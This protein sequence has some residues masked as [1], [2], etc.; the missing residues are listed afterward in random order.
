MTE[1][2]SQDLV[3]GDP[4][5]A[6]GRPPIGLRTKLALLVVAAAIPLL[7]LTVLLS[8]RSYQAERAQIEQHTV[9]T[10]HA[11]A[12]AVDREMAA[13]QSALV[14]LSLSNELRNGDLRGFYSQA[15]ELLRQVRAVNLVVWDARGLQ[16]LN[17]SVPFGQKVP[18]HAS[19]PPIAPGAGTGRPVISDLHAGHVGDRPALSVD[20]Q[21]QTALGPV[22]LSFGVQP[23]LLNDI[24]FQQPLPDNWIISLLDSSGAIVARTKGIETFLGKKAAPGLLNALNQAEEGTA[25]VRTLDG[26]EV[27]SA[28]SRSAISGWTAVIGIPIE[29]LVAPL[30]RSLYAIVAVAAALLLAGIALAALIARRI[31]QPIQALVEPALAL[32]RGEPL[33]IPPL[34]LREARQLGNAI[35]TAAR[36]LKAR[37]GQRDRAEAQLRESELRFRTMADSAPVM[38]WMSGPDKSGVYF[39]KV[40][41][42][43]TGRTLEEELGH[44]WTGNV[45]PDDLPEFRACSAAFE[46]R[47][48]FQTRF[49][50]LRHDGAWRWV[51]DT[52]IPRFETDGSFAGFIGSCLDIT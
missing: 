7:A 26:I 35:E 5:G 47:R 39:N 2:A 21:A 43:F 34:R 6:L 49:R 4:V 3:S 40:W 28:F 24:L 44:R 23:E 48:P 45:H 20:L 30:R 11:L 9:E 17:T 13:L 14:V 42:D 8:I 36:L 33:P 31:E 12:L 19:A 1:P 51:L 50:M 46:M 37:E 25:E 16:L 32:G 52:G 41:L 15:E 27:L 29:H 18:Q 10:A 22:T 38:I